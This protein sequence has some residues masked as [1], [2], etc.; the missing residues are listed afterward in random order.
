[1]D[2]DTDDLSPLAAALELS[3]PEPWSFLKELIEI[4]VNRGYLT[5][6]DVLIDQRILKS[7]RSIEP[8]TRK[9]LQE[10]NIDLFHDH[11]DLSIFLEALEPTTGMISLDD[12]T[13]FRCT[14][15][16]RC[17]QSWNDLTTTSKSNIRSCDHCNKDVVK[18]GNYKELRSAVAQR[19]C[20]FIE[21]T[22]P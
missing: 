9:A 1:M 11:P 17:E 3:D 8:A 14:F 16:F 4:G 2:L 22:K 12:V 13:E 21:S 19:Q 15:S 6:A 7:N 10:F 5:H 18:C 20:V